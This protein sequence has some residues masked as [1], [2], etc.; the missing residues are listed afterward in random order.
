MVVAIKLSIII[1]LIILLELNKQTHGNETGTKTGKTAPNELLKKKMKARVQK[2]QATTAGMIKNLCFFSVF[3]TIFRRGLRNAETWTGP[4]K[5]SKT[6][7][8]FTINSKVIGGSATSY[9]K[10]DTLPETIASGLN[11]ETPVSK[12]QT[13]IRDAGLWP[14]EAEA[15]FI[16]GGRATVH[17]LKSFGKEG[18]EELVITFVKDPKVNYVFRGKTGS[19]LINPRKKTVKTGSKSPEKKGADNGHVFYISSGVVGTRGLKEEEKEFPLGPDNK[20][21]DLISEIKKAKLWPANAKEIY[22]NEKWAS[23]AQK[24]GT[25]TG[26][27]YN[28]KIEFAAEVK[29]NRANY[30]FLVKKG[31][32]FEIIKDSSINA[33]QPKITIEAF[34]RLLK[35][36]HIWPKQKGLIMRIGGRLVDDSKVLRLYQVNGLVKITFSGT[37]YFGIKGSD[38]IYIEY[39]H[40]VKV[41]GSNDFVEA[42]EYVNYYLDNGKITEVL[43]TL[44]SPQDVSNTLIKLP[45]E[46]QKNESAWM[47]PTI[48]KLVK[49]H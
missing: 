28:S 22:I 32:D 5:C 19:T 47:S 12:L 43:T 3:I 14:P 1:G 27:R 36:T 8:T 17:K 4:A 37:F 31:D 15:M 24:L 39:Q 20:V 38:C 18:T 49:G 44:H 9:G 7:Y 6:R 46:Q 41:R 13:A 42:S 23:D 25:F 2:A 45:E 21:S 10:I 33:V 48:K 29:S 11:K 16:N 34:K 26:K 40:E 35:A 30:I